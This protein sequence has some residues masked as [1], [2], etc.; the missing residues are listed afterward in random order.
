MLIQKLHETYENC[1]E[2][3]D[4]EGQH[5][6]LLIMVLQVHIEVIINEK[7]FVSVSILLQDDKKTILPVPI[8]KR[9]KRTCTSII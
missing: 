7:E 3:I 4:K 6:C 2:L 9:D 5:L 8:L 1:Y